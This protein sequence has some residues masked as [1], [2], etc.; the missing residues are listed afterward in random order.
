MWMYFALVI[1][2]VDVSWGKVISV[3]AGRHW[4]L[5]S[6]S[7]ESSKAVSSTMVTASFTH[8]DFCGEQMGMV[9]G[10]LGM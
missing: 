3:Q 6:E 10:S 4:Q 8:P 1:L 7:P 9:S 2:L 5:V